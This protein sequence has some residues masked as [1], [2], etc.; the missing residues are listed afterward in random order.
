MKF[1]FVLIIQGL[2][3]LSEQY[4]LQKN[5]V[6]IIIWVTHEIKYLNAKFKSLKS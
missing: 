1:I 2:K 5:T 4:C 3:N 6:L